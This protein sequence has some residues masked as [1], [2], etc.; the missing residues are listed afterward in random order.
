[1]FPALGTFGKFGDLLAARPVDHCLVDA[2]DVVRCKIADAIEGKPLPRPIPSDILELDAQTL[3]MVIDLQLGLQCEGYYILPQGVGQRTARRAARLHGSFKTAI[4]PHTSG[5]LANSLSKTS[6]KDGISNR[7]AAMLTTRY[8]HLFIEADDDEW[9]AVG[10]PAVFAPID[11]EIEAPAGNNTE[12]A[13][14]G[15]FTMASFLTEILARTGPL[16]LTDL[17]TEALKT[18]PAD[19][20]PASIGPSL[21]MHR[22]TFDRVLPGVYALRGLVPLGRDLIESSPG[23]LL[24]SEQA[25][26]FAMGRR[27]GEPWGAYTLWTCEAEYALC[28]WARQNAEPALLD[29]LLAVA[30]FDL[31]PVDDATR[32]EWKTFAVQKSRT[33]QLHFQPR[34]EVGY[35]LPRADRLLAACLEARHAGHFDWMV[36]NRILNKMADSHFS[37]GLIVLMGTLGALQINPADNWYRDGY[38]DLC[39]LYTTGEIV[40]WFGHIAEASEK[41]RSEFDHMAAV[42]EQPRP[43]CGS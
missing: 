43:S 31:W 28:S 23:Y 42:G 35:A 10:T 24:N 17:Q 36:G 40:D 39:R 18:L 41:M 9:F 38:L 33:Y 7:Y 8:P 16:R 13:D 15:G 14:S 19:R 12:D 25:R 32:A 3:A 30:S 29:S 11:P 5:E 6:R 21:L 2:L 34:A 37:A 27:A 26:L 4:A 1:M 22:E 20:S